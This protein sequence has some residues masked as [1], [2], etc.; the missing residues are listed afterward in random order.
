MTLV[1]AYADVHFRDTGSFIPFNRIG[2]NGISLELENIIAGC[3][4]IADKIRELKP[5][6]VF[7]CGDIVQTTEYQT[8]QVLY[9]ISVGL[10]LIKNACD[11]VSAKHIIYLGNHDCLNEGFKIT[12]IGMLIG[13]AQIVLEPVIID[14]DYGCNIGIVPYTSNVGHLYATLKSYTDQCSLVM[15]H[16]DFHG[17]SYENNYIS[18]SNLECDWNCDIVAGDIHLPQTIGSVHYPGSLVQHRFYQPDLSRIGGILT[19]DIESKKITR[20]PN[21]YS[22]H[23]VRVRD[24]QQ[25]QFLPKDKCVIQV[26]M[27]HPKE[28]IEKYMEGYEW[29]YVREVQGNQ[30][31]PMYS[32]FNILPPETILRS[33]ILENR[34]QAL[35]EFDSVI[36]EK[37]GG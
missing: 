27:P 3:R 17:C 33:Y 37:V 5:T 32:E 8:A 21:T 16:A 35:D 26:V 22:R 13:Y 19:Y 11:E 7:G 30:M 24:I 9:G 2:S 18:Q 12:S 25:L 29:M 6:V 14:V 20:Y 34:P 4:F 28:E 1:L 10:G 23:Y 15:A 36:K 31:T